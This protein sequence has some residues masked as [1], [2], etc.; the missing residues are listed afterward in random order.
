MKTIAGME[1]RRVAL[2]CDR[3][4]ELR[5]LLEERRMGIITDLRER[6]KDTNEAWTSALGNVVDSAE[7]AETSIQDDLHFA[8]LQMQ[9]ETLDRIDEAL[10]R[11]DAGQYGLCVDCG[12][13]ISE[14]RL[15]ALPFARRC[16]GCEQAG[17]V[18]IQQLRNGPQRFLGSR[19]DMH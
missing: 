13:E 4:V 11:L 9:T 14:R 17:E 16:T 7:S 2:T 18:R 3:Q 12:D 1:T 15:Q 8:L 6:V 5:R 19:F 10:S